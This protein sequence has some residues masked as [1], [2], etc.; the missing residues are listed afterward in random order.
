MAVDYG[1]SL[2]FDSSS[3]IVALLITQFVGFPAA[4]AFGWLGKRI[5]PRAASCWHRRVR[6]RDGLGLLPRKRR[7]S[8][9]RWPS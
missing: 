1:L 6:R 9:T 8:F 4:L 3:L 2:G 7:A 5:G